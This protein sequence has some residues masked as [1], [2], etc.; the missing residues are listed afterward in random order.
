MISL[1]VRA[2]TFADNAVVSS[3]AFESVGQVQTVG[4]MGGIGNNTF[5]PKDPYTREQNIITMIRLW[6]IVK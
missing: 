4:I 2:A 3:W 5:A 1:P 6:N